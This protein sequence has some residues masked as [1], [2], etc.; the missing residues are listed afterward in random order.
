MAY[1]CTQMQGP[2]DYLQEIQKFITSQYWNSGL[3]ITSGVMVPMLIMAYQGWLSTG[4]SFLFGGLFVSLTDTPGPIHHRRNGMLIATALNTFAVVMTGLMYGYPYL[5][6]SEILIF[7]FLFSLFGIYGNRGGAIGTLAIVVMLIHMSPFRQHDQ[8]ALDGLLTAAGGLWYTALS[9]LLYRF[10][11]YR[12]VE[13]ALGENLMLIANYIRARA[14]FYKNGSSV[15]DTFNRVMKEQVEVLKSQTQ[16]RE[17]LF[18]TRQFVG[19]ASPKSRSLMM[20]FLESLDLFEETMYSY[21][22]YKRLHEQVPASLLNKFYHLALQVVAEL[23]HI[24]LFVQAGIPVKRMPKLEKALD[25]LDV[26]ILENDNNTLSAAEKHSLVAL[27][28]TIQNIRG[29]VSRLRNIVRY[30]R[31]ESYDPD[32][33]PDQELEKPQDSDPVTISLLKE[34]LTL[35]SNY[36][37]YAIRITSAL[38]I[39]FGASVLLSLSHA[40]WVMLTIITILKPLYNLTRKRNTQRVLGTL[41]GVAL[42]SGILYLISDNTALVVVMILSMLVAYSLLRINYLGF[43]LFLTTYILITF[44][45][46]NPIQFK[47]LIAERL[48]DTLIGSVIAALAARFIFPVWQQYNIQPAMKKMLVSNTSYFLSAW[49]SLHDPVSHRKQYNSARNAAIVALTNLSDNFQQMLAEPGQSGQYSAVHQFVIASHSLTSRISSL[50]RKDLSA[51][52]ASKWADK[53]VPALQ[54]AAG[55]LE[56]D[57]KSSNTKTDELPPESK[58]PLHTLSIIYSLALDIRNIAKQLPPGP[59]ESGGK[60]R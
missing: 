14:A 58:D 47:S 56:S 41:G 60:L 54:Q 16:L 5:L 17:L 32:R 7:S 28:Q 23:D 24:G 31:M 19:D 42:G 40:Y 37:R 30:T 59:A 27:Q 12:T 18:K 53:I 49:N 22:D 25:A 38:L 8:V 20:I 35:R 44:H 55:Y 51:P 45:F 4:M 36:F 21:L 6:L 9:L 2:K 48:L 34:N 10:Q 43:V 26:A 11:P 3:R 15:E 57:E 13:Q 1:F 29:I 33:F 39:G 52:G 46:L 50:S